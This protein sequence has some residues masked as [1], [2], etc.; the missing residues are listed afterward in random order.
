MAAHDDAP[1]V[2][3]GVVVDFEE[4]LVVDG[5]LDELAALGRAED[6]RPAVHDEVHGKDVEHVADVGHEPAEFLRRDPAS[7]THRR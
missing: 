7:S 1:R 5:E 6:D 4:D 3:V 2:G